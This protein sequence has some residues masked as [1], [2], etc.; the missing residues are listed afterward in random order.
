MK[1]FDYLE[2]NMTF[3]FEQTFTIPSWWTDEGFTATSDTP[4]K[5]DK[6]L[7]L[8]RAIAEILSGE[9]K[10]SL[11]IW[12]H[13]QYETFDKDGNPSFVV[14]MD[15]G[16]IEVKT[17][18]V[19]AKDVVSMIT[20]LFEAADKSGLVPYRN[21]WY[22]VQGGTEGGCHVNMG[23]FSDETNPFLKFPDLV[24]KYSAYVHNRPFLHYPFMALDVGP[25]GNAQRLD[26]KKGFDKVKAAFKTFDST[27]NV[28]EHFKETNII[29]DKSSYPS[30]HKFKEPLF[31]IEDRAVE[32]LRSPEDFELMVNLRLEVFKQLLNNTKVEKIK[33]FDESLHKEKLTSY[34]LW[35]DFQVL[36]N[37]INLSPIPFQRFFERQFPVLEQGPR[38][39]SFGIRDGRR[40]RVIK[41]I[42]KK[43]DTVICKTVD[44]DYKR[45]EF[46]TYGDE[47]SSVEMVIT[48]DG[49]EYESEILQHDAPLGFRDSGV[50]YYKYIDLKINKDNP[51]MEI[52]MKNDQDIEEAKFH[53]LDMKWI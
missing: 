38:P 16:S 43:G 5:R 17:Q 51:I 4:L 42:K 28:Y 41:D 39:N 45:F 25:E 53:L 12:D 26:E 34:S 40:P 33:D 3:G 18:P 44:T 10:E 36:A 29:S 6:M 48:V 9:F 8:A 19:I 24:V 20:P 11:D 31:L 32:S 22:G 52:S 2:Q 23:G 50:A 35:R 14:T 27:Q 37:K 21:W 49:V 15:P 1:N 47:F 7:E 30:L 46:Y 13:M